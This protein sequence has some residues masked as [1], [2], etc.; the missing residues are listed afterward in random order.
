M[1]DG[2]DLVEGDAELDASGLDEE[3]GYAPR[4]F[5][6]PAFLQH[7]RNQGQQ[8]LRADG[9]G[10]KGARAIFQ[11]RRGAFFLG[12]DDDYRD[13]G[14]L[15]VRAHACEHFVAVQLGHGEIEQHRR[16]RE[17]R[18]LDQRLS[19]V[20]RRR[21]LVMGREHGLLEGEN[22]FAI[23]DEQEVREAHDP[24]LL[25]NCSV[26]MRGD[27]RRHN[28]SAPALALLRVR[29]WSRGAPM[30]TAPPTSDYEHDLSDHLVASHRLVRLARPVQ[31]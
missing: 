20:D 31:R 14:E 23:V 6:A 26:R 4:A 18:E 7:A 19:P 2:D 15:R 11:A 25:E 21:Y 3:S 22:G 28:D 29:A 27:F 8:L 24:D 10:E 16:R 5:L 17:L 12:G 9:L 30:R 1:D 13:P